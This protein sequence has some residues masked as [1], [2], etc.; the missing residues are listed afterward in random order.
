[1]L[2]EGVDAATV[3]RLVSAGG[4]ATDP[5]TGGPIEVTKVLV[6][7]EENHSLAQMKAAMPIMI[8][9]MARPVRN[10]LRV[11]ASMATDV[12]VEKSVRFIVSLPNDPYNTR[13]NA[14]DVAERL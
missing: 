9:S 13:R 12:T 4:S 3:G 7:V 1:V 11:M 2:V 10:W 5:A 8:P 6:F 14:D